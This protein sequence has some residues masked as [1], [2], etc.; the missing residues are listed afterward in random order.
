MKVEP[1]GKM[2][3]LDNWSLWL[4]G[5]TWSRKLALLL[6]QRLSTKSIPVPDII[7]LEEEINLPGV[8]LNT[9][10]PLSTAFKL[11]MVLGLQSYVPAAGAVYIHFPKFIQRLL[12]SEFKTTGDRLLNQIKRQVS[13]PLDL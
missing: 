1:R 6:P 8:W 3:A 11:L 2:V 4:L 5:W 10:R 7:A 13:L 12:K 9:N